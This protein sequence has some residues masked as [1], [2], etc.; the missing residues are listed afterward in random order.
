MLY[1]CHW[2][3]VCYFF[4]LLF[5]A[6]S[7]RNLQTQSFSPSGSM[8]VFKQEQEVALLSLFRSMQ[9]SWLESYSK[10]RCN[11]SK[12]GWSFHPS[13]FS[14]FACALLHSEE[15]LLI[16]FFMTEGSWCKKLTIA[17][18][19]KTKMRHHWC[20][21]KRKVRYWIVNIFVCKCPLLASNIPLQSP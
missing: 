8:M 9:K 16:G 19:K 5:F 20:E 1:F 7:S 4:A 12:W 6:K 3:T 11:V 13:L 21:E 2:A 10:Y 17:R 14:C 15:I 18:R